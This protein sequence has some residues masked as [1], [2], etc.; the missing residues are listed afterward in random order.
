ME[1][2]NVHDLALETKESADK[3]ARQYTWQEVLYNPSAG[4]A[5]PFDLTS[6]LGGLRAANL[7]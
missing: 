3:W 5:Q 6:Q 2:G 7:E 1:T 4:T